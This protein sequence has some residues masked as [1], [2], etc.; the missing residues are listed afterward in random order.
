MVAKEG[1]PGESCN[2]L[3]AQGRTSCN[4]VGR[5]LGKTGNEI[6]RRNYQYNENPDRITHL[7][8]SF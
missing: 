3:I 7:R 6:K 4:D 2:S 8:I 5:P 1:F